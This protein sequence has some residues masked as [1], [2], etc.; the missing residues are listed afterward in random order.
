MFNQFFF[1]LFILKFMEEY[2]KK[3]EKNN[4]LNAVQYIN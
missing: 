2:V 3:I 1:E 4:M